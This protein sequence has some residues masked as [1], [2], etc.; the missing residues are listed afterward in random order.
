M[1]QLTVS[2]LI[3]SLSLELLNLKILVSASKKSFM[4]RETSGFPKSDI[5]KQMVDELKFTEST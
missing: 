5:E 4:L 3:V 1:Y 2:L